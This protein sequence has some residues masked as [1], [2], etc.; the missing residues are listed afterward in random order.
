MKIKEEKIIY[1]VRN[2]FKVLRYAVPN[3]DMS[4]HFHPEYELVTIIQGSG[5]RYIGNSVQKFHSGD[6]VFVGPNLGHMWV[7]DQ[8]RNQREKK[9]AEAIVLQF[10]KDLFTSMLETPEFRT[11]KTL[12]TH[13]NSGLKF[14][15]TVRDQVYEKLLH[16][17]DCEGIDCTIGLIEVLKLLAGDEDVI[18]L[19]LDNKSTIPG[20]KGDRI[21][22][23]YQFVKAFY[24]EKITVDK[25]ASIAN[26]EKSAFCRFFK[27]KTNKTFSQ[28]LNETR[29]DHVCELL[30]EGKQSV[31]RIA[32]ECGFNNMANFYRQFK[33]ITGK[34]PGEFVG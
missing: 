17:I 1:P 30:L 25:A 24:Y 13:A 6:M 28:F 29:I 14:V 9:H 26:M 31:S 3:F 21:N 2:S 33:K 23:V 16:M 34:T 27:D 15:N 8:K 20:H 19:N 22:A 7:S 18:F 10:S 32:Y 4:F 5:V 11:I 12:L